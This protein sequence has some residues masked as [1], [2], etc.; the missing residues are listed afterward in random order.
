VGILPGHI[1]TPGPM[2][3]VS[4]SGTLT[5]EVVYAAD[6]AGH[7]PEHVPWASAATRSSARTFIDALQMFE[8]D[9]ETEAS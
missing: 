8:D 3:V 6:R 5:Y 9:P 4:R 7:R 1:L 2:G